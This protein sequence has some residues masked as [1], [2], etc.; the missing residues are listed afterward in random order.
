MVDNRSITLEQLA[1][2]KQ[3]LSF[4]ARDFIP[5]LGFSEYNKRNDLT[6][7]E[8]RERNLLGK[9]MRNGVVL[10]LW[11]LAYTAAT[12]HGAITFLRQ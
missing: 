3:S 10:L 8:Y 6:N 9:S 4:R 11:N 1:D 7:G 2:T 5:Y 12:A